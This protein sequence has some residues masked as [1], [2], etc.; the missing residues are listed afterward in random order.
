MLSHRPV[1]LVAYWADK[2]PRQIVVSNTNPARPCT[3]LPAN[4]QV[5]ALAILDPNEPATAPLPSVPG[6]AVRN[7]S[8][9]FVE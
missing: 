3:V 5:E 9:V 8:W 6:H 1:P 2:R 7:R 4:K